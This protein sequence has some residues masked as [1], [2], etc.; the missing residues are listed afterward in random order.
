MYY[1]KCINN[2]QYVL[3]CNMHFILINY[4]KYILYDTYVKQIFV[5]IDFF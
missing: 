2:L 5:V 4:K 3:L 1:N